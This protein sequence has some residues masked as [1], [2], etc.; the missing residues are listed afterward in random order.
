M[1]SG[2]ELQTVAFQ[3]DDGIFCPDCWTCESPE[4]ERD[5]RLSAYYADE[6]AGDDGLGSNADL[7]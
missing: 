6:L 2:I 1:M 7:F 3:D 4:K 5:A